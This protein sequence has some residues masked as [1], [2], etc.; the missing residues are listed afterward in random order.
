MLKALML[1]AVVGV[2]GSG[3]APG[4]TRAPHRNA[5]PD[6]I[7][8]G[9][10]EGRTP[11][12]PIANE[13][14]GFPSQNCEKIKWELTFYRDAAGQPKSFRYR[15]TRTTRSGSWTVERRADRGEVFRLTP[16]APGKPLFLL[17]V[18][19]DVLL[20]LDADLRVVVGDAS[21]SYAFNRTDKGLKR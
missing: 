4:G 20:L 16:A 17:N 14:T 2:M 7:A 8:M 19:G 5:L 3:W 11:C 12:H 1:V 10:F 13:F 21:W 15:G 9:V 6:S 18:D